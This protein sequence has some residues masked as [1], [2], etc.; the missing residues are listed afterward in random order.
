MDRTYRYCTNAFLQIFSHLVFR[1][2]I[3]IKKIIESRHPLQVY[4]YINVLYKYVVDLNED[5]SFT[6]YNGAAESLNTLIGGYNKHNSL[7]ES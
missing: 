6:A 1:V 4:T 5:Y 3:K 7:L 2:K